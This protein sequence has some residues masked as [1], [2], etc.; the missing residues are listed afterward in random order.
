M[1]SAINPARF[2]LAILAMLLCLVVSSPVSAGEPFWIEKV[3]SRHSYRFEPAR[4]Y[5][6]LYSDREYVYSELPQCMEGAFVL[7]TANSDKFTRGNQFLQIRT[8]VP[9]RVYVGYD[10]RYGT[11]PDWLLQQ[12]R[13]VDA[14]AVAGDAKSGQAGIVYQFYRANFQPGSIVLGGNLH[15]RENGNFAMYTVVVVPTADDRCRFAMR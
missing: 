15:D 12:Y 3:D 2:V 6:F 10:I 14:R 5:A 8:D 7:I 11:R 9:L 4:R 1:K 13:E